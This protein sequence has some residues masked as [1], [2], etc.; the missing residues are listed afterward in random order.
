MPT[1]G[2]AASSATA[3]FTS[4]AAAAAGWAGNGPVVVSFVLALKV[5]AVVIVSS[6][7]CVREGKKKI[8]RVY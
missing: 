8:S 2:R 3:T 5:I 4:T 1:F 6:A 7:A